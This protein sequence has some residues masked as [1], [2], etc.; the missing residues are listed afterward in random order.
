VRGA[1]LSFD[2]EFL[3]DLF[4]NDGKFAAKLLLVVTDTR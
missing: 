3:V 4:R 1:V 2:H